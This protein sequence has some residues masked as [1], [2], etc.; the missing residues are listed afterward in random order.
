MLTRD[1]KMV[2]TSATYEYYKTWRTIEGTNADR[3][4]EQKIMTI[5][6]LGHIEINMIT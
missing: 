5:E 4:R 2:T 3:Q 1:R 6:N